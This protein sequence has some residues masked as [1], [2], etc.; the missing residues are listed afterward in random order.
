MV[1]LDHVAD[2]VNAGIP[3]DLIASQRGGELVGG[4]DIGRMGGGVSEGADQFGLRPAVGVLVARSRRGA[5][6]HR[7]GDELVDAVRVEAAEKIRNS[8]GWEDVKPW[9]WPGRP[10][11][12]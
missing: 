3:G 4:E 10:I 8:V 12:E 11:N 6:A 5:A 9:V 7:G 1:P 2:Q